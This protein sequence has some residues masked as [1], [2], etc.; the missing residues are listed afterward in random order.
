MELAKLLMCMSAIK[1]NVLSMNL[2]KVT[3]VS[4]L[5]LNNVYFN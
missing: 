1:M 2:Q 5:V 4:L 3:K